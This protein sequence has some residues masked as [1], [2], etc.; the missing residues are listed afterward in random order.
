M[1]IRKNSII[2]E[3]ENP[4]KKDQEV[5]LS[6]IEDY[7]NYISA[8]DDGTQYREAIDQN[9]RILQKLKEMGATSITW[10]K[11]QPMFSTV[12]EDKVINL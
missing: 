10:E 6:L 7:D 3:T 12:Q 2:I 11:F 4:V 8:I 9:K 1:K 5:M